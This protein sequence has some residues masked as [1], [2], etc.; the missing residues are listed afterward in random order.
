MAAPDLGAALST[1]HG[2]TPGSG[3]GR[4]VAPGVGMASAGM[5][6]QAP[7]GRTP[8]PAGKGPLPPHQGGD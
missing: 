3:P 6:Q 5:D 1:G 7:Q 8:V 4:M 2:A